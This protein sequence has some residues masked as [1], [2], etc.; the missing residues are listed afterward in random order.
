MQCNADLVVRAGDIAG[1]MARMV[2]AWTHG[3]LADAR[4][5]TGSAPTRRGRSIP[6]VDDEVDR[7]FTLQTADV[8]VTEVVA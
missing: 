6:L 8:S 4:Q 3:R 1:Y 2:G 7:H 5:S